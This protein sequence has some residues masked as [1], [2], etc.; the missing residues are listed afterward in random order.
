VEKIKAIIIAVVGAMILIGIEE[1]I[2]DLLKRY[3]R[4]IIMKIA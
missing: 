4:L 2:D 3:S 1:G